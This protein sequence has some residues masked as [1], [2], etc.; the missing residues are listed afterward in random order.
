MRLGVIGPKPHKETLI[1]SIENAL[2]VQARHLVLPTRRRGAFLNW[3]EGEN[4]PLPSQQL[5]VG[6]AV[7]IPKVLF[8]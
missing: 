1:Y 4:S 5:I 8:F 2:L 6:F 7:T 3:T